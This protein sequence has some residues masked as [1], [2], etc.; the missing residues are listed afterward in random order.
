[1]SDDRQWP[2]PREL[3]EYLKRPGIKKARH[4]FRRRDGRCCLGHYADMCG[5]E[6]PD[7]Q[8]GF[9][10]RPNTRG[11]AALPEGHVAS[12]ALP[13]IRMVAAAQVRVPEHGRLPRAECAVRPGHHQRLQRRVQRGDPVPGAARRRARGGAV[14]AKPLYS[15]FEELKAWASDPR[16]PHRYRHPVP[17]QHDERRPGPIR[18]HDGD[19]VL[20]GGQDQLRTERVRQKIRTFRS[21]STAWRCRPGRWRHASLRCSPGSRPARSR[22][23]SGRKTLRIS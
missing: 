4:Q 21:C 19:G 12:P 14:T 20:R 10:S 7:E 1:M 15:A 17:G 9:K 16:P 6:Y 11:L 5:L 3:A 2:G 13:R 18:I 23:S 22:P 8:V